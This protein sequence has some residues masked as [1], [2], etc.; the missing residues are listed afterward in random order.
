[1]RDYRNRKQLALRKANNSVEREFYGA[2]RRGVSNALA[3]WSSSLTRDVGNA[4][5][6]NINDH[7]RND[8]IKSAVSGE[9]MR[10][11]AKSTIL[12]FSRVFTYRFEHFSFRDN[13]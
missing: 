11:N 10:E 2:T 9:R 5:K 6:A 7:E 8:A 12:S 1:M 3:R 13:R 4:T